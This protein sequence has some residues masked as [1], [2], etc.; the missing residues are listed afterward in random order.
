MHLCLT[1]KPSVDSELADTLFDD[2][3]DEDTTEEDSDEEDFSDEDSGGTVDSQTTSSGPSDNIKD[4]EYVNFD[5]LLIDFRRIVSPEVESRTVP[6][7][8]SKLNEMFEEML[9][10]ICI[11]QIS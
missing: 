10:S 9:V 1:R 2:P 6:L 11:L 5:Q 8:D 3:S 7:S 4:L